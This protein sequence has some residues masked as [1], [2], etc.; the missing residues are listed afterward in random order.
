MEGKGGNDT[1]VVDNAGDDV[2]EASNGGTDT[3]LSSISYALG[4]NAENL[5]LT[6]SAAINGLGNDRANTLVGNKADNM[7]DGGAG[8]DDL[9]GGDGDDVY[10]VDNTGDD[11][12]ESSNDGN[13]TVRSSVNFTLD[14]NVENLVLTGT[15]ALNGT[16]NSLN[17]ILVGNGTANVLKAGSG[18]DILI[19][20]AGADSL[21]GGSDYSRDVFVFQ[22]IGD[23]GKTSSTWDRVYDFDRNIDKLDFSDIDAGTAAGDQSFRFVT[24]FSAGSTGQIRAV[25][26]GSDVRVEVDLQ[27]DNT[28]DMVIQVMNAQYLRSAD[29]IL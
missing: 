25:S 5:T 28:V 14:G 4:A 8:A 17:N 22:A 27:G 16:G 7:L 13:D 2:V 24:S 26:S 12:I 18:G 9:K 29:F 10:V 11:V 3:V 15:S 21:Y 23:S 1:Y 20:G 6:G 19:G